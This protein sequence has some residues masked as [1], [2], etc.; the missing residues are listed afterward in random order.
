M[1]SPQTS[2][3]SKTEK[4]PIL[5]DFGAMVR[6]YRMERGLSQETFADACEIDRSYMGGVERGERNLALV[7]II[8]IVQAL[9]ME[10]SEFFRGLDKDKRNEWRAKEQAEKDRKALMRVAGVKKVKKPARAL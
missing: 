10:P 2:S 1:R 4:L 3:M 8:R 6:A 5:E 7:N 9:D